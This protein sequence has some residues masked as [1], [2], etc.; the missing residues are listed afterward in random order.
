MAQSMI[1]YQNEIEPQT[2]YL[3][4]TNEMQNLI[5]NLSQGLA[6][7]GQLNQDFFQDVKD[8]TKKK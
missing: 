3:Q 6:A 7:D 5:Y 4:G 8:T 2:T 1:D